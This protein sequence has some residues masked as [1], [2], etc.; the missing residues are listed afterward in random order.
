MAPLALA[1]VAPVA[2][3]VPEL[4]PFASQERFS[5]LPLVPRGAHSLPGR[6][7]LAAG[8]FRCRDL[9]RCGRCRNFR[10]LLY[11]SGK[12]G[13]RGHRHVERQGLIFVTL[14]LLLGEHVIKKG[15]HIAMHV[16]DVHRRALLDIFSRVFGI[17]LNA[18]GQSA[19][20]RAPTSF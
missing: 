18:P 14:T 3:P 4:P 12:C 7:A 20:L 11:R 1:Q 16:R 2:W 15:F 8:A 19:G 17:G 6:L 10:L 5:S 9:R 13:R